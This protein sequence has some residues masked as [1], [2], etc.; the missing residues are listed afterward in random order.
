[1]KKNNN[2]L[3]DSASLD[4]LTFDECREIYAKHINS[5]KTDLLASF[6]SSRQKI[7]SA[8]GSYIISSDGDRIL[9]CTG[10]YGVLNHGHNHPRIIKARQ[11]VLSDKKMEVNKN[12]FSPALA[13]LSYNMSQILFNKLE[14]SFF[15]NSGSE[16]VDVA[17]RLCLL[18]AE[19][20]KSGKKVFLV[21]D[22]AFHGKSI[23]AQSLSFSDENSIKL[24]TLI[25]IEKYEFNKPDSLNKYKNRKDIAGVLVEPF[26]ASTMTETSD[27]MLSSLKTLSKKT[28]CPLI[29][30][31]VYSGWY[32]TGNLFN[33][34]RESETFW[35]DILCYGKAL[36]GGK[37]S[38][39]GISYSAQTFQDLLETNKHA[40]FLSSTY[41]GFY[42]ETVTA[43]E[44]INI[45]LEENAEDKSKE[46]EK[47]MREI[48]R[49]LSES[50]SKYYLNGSGMLWGLFF[51][52]NLV[53][54]FLDS[55]NKIFSSTII[56]DK[57]ISKKACAAA[58]I[59][60]LYRKYQILAGISF[61]FNTHIILSFGIMHTDEDLSKVRTAINELSKQ[62]ILSLIYE[63]LKDNTNFKSD[64]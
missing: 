22:R 39:S 56:K 59:A 42:E 62:N 33:F 20:N 11:K 51:E 1:M 27:I 32:K 45:L 47:F 3:I 6:M 38:I 2:G 58:I 41:Y 21:S 34:M 26:S 53:P 23:L 64:S 54:N 17:F 28:D 14:Y 9:D 13:A 55:I 19:E 50:N 40:N 24:S 29:Y 48:N 5:K 43:I 15:P 30:D 35:P 10:G 8:E 4:N 63:F 37:S 7:K 18:K 36:G 52:K 44:A 57:N 31:E 12:F 49:E 25:N 16:S 46:I 60:Y 61:G